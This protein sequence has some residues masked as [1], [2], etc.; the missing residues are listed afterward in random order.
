MRAAPLHSIHPL[1]A[2]AAPGLALALALSAGAG[3]GADIGSGGAQE[4]P[5]AGFVPSVD[6]SPPAP[7]AAP[8]VPCVAEGD[9]M[10]VLDR[11]GSM[12]Q[13]PDGTMPPNTADGARETKWYAAVTTIKSVA[14]QLDD[15]IHFGLELFPLDPEGA[16]GTDCSNLSTW[17]TQY[18]P[19]ETND[20]ACNPAE[21]LVQPALHTASAIDTAIDVDNTGL[22]GWTPTGAGISAAADS[23]MQVADPSRPQGVLLITDGADTCDDHDGYTTLSL[24]AADALAAA[25]MTLYVVGF[26]GSGE[27]IDPAELND[28]A[29]AGHSAPGF[30]KNCTM[31]AA[32]YRAVASPSPARLF[33]LADDQAGLT[34]AI[35]QVAGDVCGGGSGPVD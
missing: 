8:A 16:G 24:P 26:D 19:P 17:L 13:R 34:Q 30:D 9:L 23:L 21:V 25:G 6:A 27:G 31:T 12:S 2:L 29:C 4:N 18:L 15:T 20:A 7:D 10:I 11:S 5:D 3:C 14:A 35:R 28:L 33:F 32:G 22:C 1:A